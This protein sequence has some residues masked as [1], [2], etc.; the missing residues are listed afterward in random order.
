MA[1]MQTTSPHYPNPWIGRIVVGGLLALVLALLAF[2]FLRPSAEDEI[3][4]NGAASV[5]QMDAAQ[6]RADDQRTADRRMP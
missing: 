2:A 4:R 3:A 1:R 6:D 5:G